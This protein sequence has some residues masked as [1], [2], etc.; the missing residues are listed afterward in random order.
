MSRFLPR[1]WTRFFLNRIPA[2]FPA[3]LHR[4][5]IYI[6]PTRAGLVLGAVLLAMLAGSLNYNNNLG[7]LLT[8]LLS[9]MVLLSLFY[10]QRNLTGLVV[11]SVITEP[12][13]AEEPV[14]L[15]VQVYGAGKPRRQIRLR[16]GD[17]IS[18]PAHIKGENRAI[19]TLFLPP[20]KRGRL[21]PGILR[22]ESD[23][24]FGLF[25]AS[26]PIRSAA[27][28]LIYPVPL[29][30]KPDTAHPK[31]GAEDPMGN[32]AA[33]SVSGA[34][35]FAGLRPYQPGDPPGRI[36]WKSL[37]RGAGLFTKEFHAFAPPILWFS[38]G[39]FN[40]T[41]PEKRLSRLCD[42]ILQA[43]RQHTPYGLLL[44]AIT[45]SP[46]NTPEHRAACLAA[47]ARFDTHQAG[48]A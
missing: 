39:D 21:T 9:G 37:S 27:E 31:P 23:I 15:S 12:V 7:F 48:S 17:S 13:F 40:E 11:E 20:A 18:S 2:R 36:S 6:L 41:D 1:W 10:T 38:Y 44:P 46:D 5:R 14:P 35:D 29:S 28:I 3:P 8:F 24:P 32:G 19:L 33:A 25:S 34:T 22:L 47:L 30:T 16:K 43:H 26:S 4:N 45:I 42:L